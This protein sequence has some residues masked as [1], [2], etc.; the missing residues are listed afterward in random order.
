MEHAQPTPA[1]A[2]RDPSFLRLRSETHGSEPVSRD[3]RIRKRLGG[4]APKGRGD[5]FAQASLRGERRHPPPGF[6]PRGPAPCTRR[7]AWQGRTERSRGCR[8]GEA[9][10]GPTTRPSDGARATQAEGPRRA[11][12]RCFLSSLNQKELEISEYPFLSLKQKNRH[13]APMRK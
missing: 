4:C 3:R 1:G 2:A 8:P 12:C 6:S 10:P 7:P 13:I 9:N 5:R 11:G